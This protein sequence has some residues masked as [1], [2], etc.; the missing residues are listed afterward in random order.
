MITVE[1]VMEDLNKNWFYSV[2]TLRSAVEC[3]KEDLVACPEI[4]KALVFDE[5]DEQILEVK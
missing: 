5:E 3:I 1:Y 2:E 4:V